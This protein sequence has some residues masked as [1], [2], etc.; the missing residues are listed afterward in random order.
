MKKA[1]IIGLRLCL[2]F[3]LRAT[4]A[5]VHEPKLKHGF[6]IELRRSVVFH[7]LSI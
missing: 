6:G 5:L 1:T 4:I 2:A 3:V 7:L